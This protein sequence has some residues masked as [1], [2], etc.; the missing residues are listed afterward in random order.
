MLTLI[1]GKCDGNLVRCQI[2]NCSCGNNGLFE[3]PAAIFEAESTRPHVKGKRQDSDSGKGLRKGA[4]GKTWRRGRE[5]LV[6]SLGRQRLV[7]LGVIDHV[8]Q[9]FEP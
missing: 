2:E 9:Q 5:L 7:D 3:F 4:L 1:R 6:L 8:G